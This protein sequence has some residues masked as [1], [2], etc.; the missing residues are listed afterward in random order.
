MST[1]TRRKD[2]LVERVVVPSEP[3]HR[4]EQAREAD[5]EDH[6]EERRADGHQLARGAPEDQPGDAEARPGREELTALA[7]AASRPGCS[8]RR[9]PPRRA[10][11]SRGST[12]RG[13]TTYVGSPS[14]TIASVAT[15][16][17]S[18]ASRAPG[19]RSPPQHHAGAIRADLSRGC[20][21]AI[22]PIL[23]HCSGPL[24]GGRHLLEAEG[25][26]RPAMDYSALECVDHATPLR[27][28]C[29]RAG[30]PS[31]GRELSPAP[32]GSAAPVSVGFPPWSGACP[33][34]VVVPRRTADP[35]G[36]RAEG[37]S[38]PERDPPDGARERRRPR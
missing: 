29:H 14:T 11:P 31:P 16:T 26:H 2:E 9:R 3:G 15:A 36:A 23:R 38:R 28:P 35:S 25:C 18:Q 21:G 12:V 1:R 30:S 37:S 27:F 24:G 4:L 5:R 20:V 19:A 13:L 10:W 22:V 32:A 33:A 34:P 8:A 6:Q 17:T 7:G